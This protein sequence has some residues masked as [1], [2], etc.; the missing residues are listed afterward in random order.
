[1]GKA[2]GTRLKLIVRGLNVHKRNGDREMGAVK[3]GSQAIGF[4]DQAS[5]FSVSGPGLSGKC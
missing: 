2:Q 1:M 4:R 3:G 5:G